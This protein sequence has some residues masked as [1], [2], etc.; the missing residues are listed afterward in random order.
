MLTLNVRSS[1]SKFSTESISGVGTDRRFNG[2][3]NLLKWKPIVPRRSLS[4]KCGDD[5]NQ[6]YI[7][8]C[9]HVIQ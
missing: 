2:S 5:R 6:V 8:S 7:S 4:R 9:R 3:P 1:G